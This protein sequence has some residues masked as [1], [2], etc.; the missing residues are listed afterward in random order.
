MF[1]FL[2]FGELQP[3]QGYRPLKAYKVA[4][5]F[6]LE[7]LKK[8]IVQAFESGLQTTALA[9]NW[10]NFLSYACAV[11]DE[12]PFAGGP[13]EDALIE[14]TA[15]NIG[16]LVHSSGI[17]DQLSYDRPNFVNRVLKAVVTLPAKA[18]TKPAAM[19]SAFDDQ[20]RRQ[21]VAQQAS[22][23]GRGGATRGRGRGGLSRV[24]GSHRASPY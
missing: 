10:D 24:N 15:G 23:T 21:Q 13:L 11:L 7:P 8:L 12:V 5:Y 14:V 1:R 3:F 17:W 4:V 2:Y 16:L 6:Q 18:S 19:T 9:K 22:S 20:L